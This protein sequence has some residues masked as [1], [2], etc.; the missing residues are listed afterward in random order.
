VLLLDEPD[1]H[2][3][4]VRQTDIYDRLTEAARD[5]RSQL[6]VATHSEVLLQK[7]VGHDTVIAF[8]GPPH[9][10]ADRGTG[11]QRALRDIGFADF[12]NARQAGFVLYVEGTTDWLVL[13]AFAKR[14][15]HLPAQRVLDEVFVRPIGNHPMEAVRH[16]HGLRE[17]LPELRAT[18]LFDRLTRSLPEMGS[19]QATTW[20]RR[21]I[22]NYLCSERTLLRWASADA[23][24]S[25]DQPN[26][27]AESHRKERRDA[28]RRALARIRKASEAIRPG[29]DPAGTD[30]K[31]SEAWLDP[32][33]RTY[34]S[35]LGRYNR[36]SK[37]RFHELAAHVPD[38]D[39]APEVQEKLDFLAAAYGKS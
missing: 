25:E 3:E 8:V 11:I 24:P 12:E 26:L 10:I 34:F 31:A 16:F 39:L 19:V 17:A 30:S 13:R 6:I 36:M 23:G 7:A 14:L 33:F 21:E 18:A 37:K 27:F 9:R 38:A 32:V 4:I 1:A 28:M 20:R 2:L 35:I 29:H 22:E 5:S 15:H